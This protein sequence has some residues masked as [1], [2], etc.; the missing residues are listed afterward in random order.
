MAKSNGLKEELKFLKGIVTYI[1]DGNVV[2]LRPCGFLK[3]LNERIVQL[4]NKSNDFICKITHGFVI[5]RWDGKGNFLGQDFVAGDQVEYE[6][7]LGVVIEDVDVAPVALDEL[8]HSFEMK[9]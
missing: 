8:Y 3:E 4:E 7:P 9:D 6:S 2:E 1:E 5:Q